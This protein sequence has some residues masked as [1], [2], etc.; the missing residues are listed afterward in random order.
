MPF[1]ELESQKIKHLIGEF[2]QNRIPPHLREKVRLE[3]KI[4]NQDVVIFEVRPVWNNPK[5]FTESL[6]AK[7]K[8]VRKQMRWKLYWMRS[9]LK[10]CLYEPMESAKELESMV[11]EIGKDPHGCFWG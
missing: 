9:N 10:W 6:I 7:I 8:F 4:T 2:C 5:E 11:Q 3:F 1:Y